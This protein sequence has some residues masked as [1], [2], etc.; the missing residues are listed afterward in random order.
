MTTAILSPRCYPV[1]D[2]L[3][4]PLPE[5]QKSGVRNRALMFVGRPRLTLR[6][7]HHYKL[8]NQRPHWREIENNA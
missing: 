3:D 6:S 7:A 4:L 1:Y 2:E 5:F 8:R